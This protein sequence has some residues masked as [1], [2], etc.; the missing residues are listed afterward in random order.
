MPWLL[1]AGFDADDTFKHT[2]DT[3]NIPDDA[4]YSFVLRMV[5][6]DA[7]ELVGLSLTILHGEVQIA[8][9]SIGAGEIGRVVMGLG[10]PTE[11]YWWEATLHRTALGNM[12]EYS[13]ISREWTATKEQSFAYVHANSQPKAQYGWSFTT[14]QLTDASRLN[15]ALFPIDEASKDKALLEI[16]VNLETAEQIAPMPDGL[17]I[18]TN[19]DTE[20]YEALMNQFSTVLAARMIKLLPMDLIFQLTMLP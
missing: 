5:E 17:T 14:K 4:A 12:A 11:N 3:T 9:I 10:L 19:T 16:E 8:S 20:D 7:A 15:A 13:G 18:C 6:D 1:A 2:D